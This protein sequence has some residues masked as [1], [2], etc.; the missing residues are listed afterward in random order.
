[1]NKFHVFHGTD[2]RVEKSIPPYHPSCPYSPLTLHFV[3][4]IV[5]EKKS[6]LCICFKIVLCLHKLIS[7]HFH[8]S[9]DFFFLQ[10]SYRIWPSWRATNH[11]IV[12]SY[13]RLHNSRVGW[14]N[15]AFQFSDLLCFER[16]LWQKT[17]QKKKWPTSCRL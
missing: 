3:L 13:T 5:F 7:F 1:M 17:K 12:L 11:S 6:N 9:S 16:R 14:E 10:Y 2:L 8:F 4:I 15:F